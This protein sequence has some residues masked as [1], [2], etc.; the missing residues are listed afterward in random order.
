MI[1]CAELAGTIRE[2]VPFYENIPR[3]RIY[4]NYPFGYI[5]C[6]LIVAIYLSAFTT[7]GFG[8]IK[9][10]STSVS[11][12]IFVMIMKWSP[13]RVKREIIS[14]KRDSRRHSIDVSAE[15]MFTTPAR[16]K[17]RARW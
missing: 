1:I 10:I 2:L 6:I 13:M 8:F 11:A 9:I 7:S 5:N 16:E 15:R 12:I 4:H 14:R 3:Y 17:E